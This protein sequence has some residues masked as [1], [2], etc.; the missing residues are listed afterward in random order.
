MLWNRLY[1]NAGYKILLVSGREEKN[2]TPTERFYQKHFPEVKYELFMRPTGD[3][4]KDVI[5]KERFLTSTLK[6]NILS[7]GR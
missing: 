6:E 1:H 2:R 3:N 7:Q 4:R 5:I